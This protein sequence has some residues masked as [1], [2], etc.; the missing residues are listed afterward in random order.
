[1]TGQVGSAWDALATLGCSNALKLIL[2]RLVHWL[3]KLICAAR[4]PVRWAQSAVKLL[5]AVSDLQSLCRD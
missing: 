2:A 4:G 3:R 5:A 1:M